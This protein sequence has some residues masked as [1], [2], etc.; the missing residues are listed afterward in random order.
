LLD[1]IGGETATLA[2]VRSVEVRLIVLSR[3]ISDVATRRADT[4][5]ALFQ[6]R[7]R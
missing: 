4:L 2:D 3:V 7:N 6:S 5:L 1:D